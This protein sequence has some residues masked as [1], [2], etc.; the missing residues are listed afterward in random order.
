[1]I[2]LNWTRYFAS[3]SWCRL[4][5]APRFMDFLEG[6]L[7]PPPSEADCERNF[8]RVIVIHAQTERTRQDR[9]ARSAD[10]HLR[11]VRTWWLRGQ[12][13]VVPAVPAVP[14]LLSGENA[15]PVIGFRRSLHQTV[16]QLG[17][18]GSE[19]SGPWGADICEGTCENLMITRLECAVK[20][21]RGER[22]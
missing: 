3:K 4:L 22:L 12:I 14:G 11:R 18:L 16:L 13:R 8:M 15:C 10:K 6:A 1:M 21:T 2:S 17:N 7:P 9:S 5:R 20:E 19:V